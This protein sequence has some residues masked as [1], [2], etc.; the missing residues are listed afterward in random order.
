[1]AQNTGQTC[2]EKRVHVVTSVCAHIPL[3]RRKGTGGVGYS[4]TLGSC[5]DKAFT[6]SGEGHN[7]RGRACPFSIRDDDSPIVFKK[8][9]T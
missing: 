4:L 1:M 7:R 6:G 9:N 3:Y 8:R 5:A 2:L